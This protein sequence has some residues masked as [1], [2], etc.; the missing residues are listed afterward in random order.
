MN[1]EL[2]FVY[3][4]NSSIL[5]KYIDLAHKIISPTT[6]SCD[7]CA[8]THGSFSEKKEW[9]EFRENTSHIFRFQYKNDFIASYKNE[10]YQKFQFPVIL[11]RKK[12]D[13]HIVLDA[14]KLKSM[15]SAEDLIKVLKEKVN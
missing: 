14:K 12:D 5:N 10:K 1:R 6:Y 2:L 11:E 7:L 4:A 3:N 8:L 9:K 13:F 15:Q